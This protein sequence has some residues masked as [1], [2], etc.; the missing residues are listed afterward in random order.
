MKKRIIMRASALAIASAL[1]IGAG[2][3]AY[4]ANGKSV[5]EEKAVA[6]AVALG[7]AEKNDIVVD[8]LN[9]TK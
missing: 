4:A 9:Y 7:D 1:I 6:E 2:G 3:S 8:S 5:E